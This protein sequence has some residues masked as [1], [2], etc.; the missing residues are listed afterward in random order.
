MMVR[1]LTLMLLLALPA[2]C[3]P[4]PT[5]PSGELAADRPSDFTLG[6]VVYGH[7]D[8]ATPPA[9]R[10]ARYIVEP[11]GVLRA[12]FGDGSRAMTHPPLARR[13]D[14]DQLDAL[15]TRVRE[16]GLGEEPWR[17]VR[18]PEQYDVRMGSGT[19]Y[20]LELRSGV[21]F[22]AWSTPLDTESARTLALHL[23]S[24]SWV[25]D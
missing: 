10:S 12:S 9:Q 17:R 16:M 20:L 11:D 21:V 15:W 6:L 24:L 7:T 8:D 18:A 25:T 22:D 14:T 3:A 5:R 19:G 4:T 23:A 2:A 13:L 1:I